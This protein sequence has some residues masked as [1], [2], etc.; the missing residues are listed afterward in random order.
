MRILLF[1]GKGGVGKSTLAAATACRSA[2]AGHRTLVLSTDAAHSLAD[3][4]DVPA[5]GEPTEAAPNL[6]VQH[7]DAQ[8]RFE[9]SW[10]DIQGYLLSVLD[11]A[12]VDPVAAEELTVIPGA[13]EVLALLEVRAQARTGEWDVLVVDCAPTAET[14]RLLA[15]PEALGWYM[16]RV[17]PV[18]RRVVKALKP[19]LT[20][21]AGVPMPSD[22]VFD[23]VER[24]H[25]ELDDVRALLTGPE[26][27]VRLVLTPE[28]VVLAEARRAYT[29]LTLFGYTVDAAV[30]NRVFPAGGADA[31]RTSWVE[32]QER[33]LA[34]AADSFAGLDLRTSVY[35]DV[36][37]V[38]HDQLLDLAA[39]V[40]GGD[41]PL[42]T[43][44]R[45]P[46]LDVRQEAGGRVLALPLPL[47]NRDDVRLARKG[48]ELVV[49]VASYRRL[50]T[51]PSGLARLRVAGARVRDGELQVRFVDEETT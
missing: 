49:S 9:R 33:V 50:L 11:V 6:W 13:E 25:A 44:V 26:A 45:R 31:W 30:V 21:A 29:F 43:S 10:R 3:A 28:A 18:E 7:V 15:L 42:S 5:T 4:L 8:E 1:T 27:S 38:G 39:A 41:D 14:L 35:R 48:D 24:L 22:S 32:A 20:R 40:Y 12:G 51:L 36:E 47:A 16:T 37:P 34:D 2:A 46:P 17:L 23:A 19:V